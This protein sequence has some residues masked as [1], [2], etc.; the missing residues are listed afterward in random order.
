MNN[1]KVLWGSDKNA[2]IFL[3][4]ANFILF[5]FF[6]CMMIIF[7][8]NPVTSGAD[9]GNLISQ[10]GVPAQQFY[11]KPWTLLTYFFSNDR[12]ML[13]LSNMLW[14]FSFAYLL[15]TVVGNRY[16]LPSYIYGGLVGAA[17]FI[18][19]NL[20]APN[21]NAALLGSTTGI[22]AVS[23]TTVAVAPN[24]KI[25]PFINGGIPLWILSALFLLINFIG[26]GMQTPY[27]LPTYI[28]AT[29]IGYAYGKSITNGNDW[30][31]W[32][33]WLYNQLANKKITSKSGADFYKATVVPY[34]K[35]IQVNQLTVDQVLDKINTTGMASL[36]K[37]E[38]AVL[39]KAKEQL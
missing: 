12:F 18:I 21:H 5:F 35:S 4:G 7:Q 22:L 20:V 38:K 31:G 9:Y 33:H 28:A 1:N 15:Q 3:I 26:V 29:A 13:L 17:V 8:N 23:A 14:L 36:T 32:M 25:F 27:M 6:R 37:A 11:T 34:N 2:V 19:T 30:G 16:L 39:E 24:Y 10:F